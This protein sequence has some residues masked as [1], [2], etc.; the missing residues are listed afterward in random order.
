MISQRGPAV[1]KILI[2]AGRSRAMVSTYPTS[3]ELLIFN[4]NPIGGAL[5][6]YLVLYLVRWAKGTYNRQER[7]IALKIPIHPLQD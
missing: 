2:P 1:R 3:D 6:L 4:P 7:P 5:V